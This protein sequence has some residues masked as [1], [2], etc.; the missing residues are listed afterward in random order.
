[1]CSILTLARRIAASVA[2]VAL[3]VCG[4]HAADSALPADIPEF[5][6]AFIYHFL[7]SKAQLPFD[8]FAWRSFL[9]LNAVGA[10]AAPD[11][12]AKAWDALPQPDRVLAGD[13][14]FGA[15][16]APQPGTVTVFR[17]RQADGSMLVD[18]DGNFIV[19]DTRINGSAQ[20]T[21]QRV[22]AGDTPGFIAGHMGAP[23]EDGAILIKTAWR[24]LGGTR[25]QAADGRDYVVVPGRIAI[26]AEDSLDHRAQC[27]AV[28]LGLLGMHIVRKPASG[29]GDHWI[30]ST[31]E[32]VATAPLASNARDVNNILSF[33]PFPDGCPVADAPKGFALFAEGPNVSGVNQSPADTYY[34]GDS[35]PFARL[36]DGSAAPRARVSR[37]WKVFAGTEAL[38]AEMRAPLAGTPWQNYRLI[39]TQWRGNGGD[40][41]FG[42]GELPRYLSN[43]SMESF[44]QAS[45]SC[46]SCHKAART[47]DGQRADF[48]FMFQDYP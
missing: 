37:C 14:P 1:M 28:P 45:G 39:G 35:A 12:T 26:A 34:W 40:P 36:A 6:A 30:W 17:Y 24:V 33:D 4:A 43:V 47:A 9:A 10:G 20:H 18:R 25:D 46:M 27:L 16:G 42:T 38:N 41:I 15:C 29:N 44:M 8:T 22:Q 13:A 3:S 5:Q 7:E 19:Y 32:H 21:V 31:F 2:S 11:S 48:T 23:Q